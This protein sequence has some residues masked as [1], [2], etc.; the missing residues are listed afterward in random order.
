MSPSFFCTFSNVARIYP[1]LVI[2]TMWIRRS[3]EWW[4]VYFVEDTQHRSRPGTVFSESSAYLLHLPGVLSVHRPLANSAGL[5][6]VQKLRMVP[7][8]CWRPVL[9][10][11]P[12][13]ESGVSPYHWVWV[14]MLLSTILPAEGWGSALPAASLLSRMPFV[15]STWTSTSWASS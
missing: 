6:P 14:E 13:A 12:G 2:V 10:M 4:V 15:P 11:C 8:C 7:V 9:G 1:S 3:P 5:V